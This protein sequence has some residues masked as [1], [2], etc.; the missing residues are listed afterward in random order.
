MRR[1]RLLF[2][3]AVVLTLSLAGALAY[4]LWAAWRFSGDALSNQYLYVVPIVV[5]FV[6]FLLDRIER[7]QQATFLEL[8]LDTAIVVTA[9]MRVIGDVPFVS[10]HALFLSY[11]LL[12]PGSMLTRVAAGLVLIEVIYLKLFVW[13]DRITPFTG[14]LLGTFAAFFSWRENKRSATLRAAAVIH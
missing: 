5:P 2:H 1:N 4:A 7:F 14:I 3:P 8:G 9:M 6:T 12:R 13:H 10:G 11:A